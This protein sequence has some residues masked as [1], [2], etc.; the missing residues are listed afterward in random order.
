MTTLSQ[1]AILKGA[2]LPD[3]QAITPEQVNSHI[4][5][6]LKDLEDAFSALEVSLEKDLSSGASMRWEAMMPFLQSIG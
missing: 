5:R 1:P 6:L 2:G 3:Y 4:P